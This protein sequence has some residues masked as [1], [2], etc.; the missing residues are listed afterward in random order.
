MVFLPIIYDF[1]LIVS[2]TSHL[3]IEFIPG[4]KSLGKFNKSIQKKETKMFDDLIDLAI[5]IAAELAKE[6]IKDRL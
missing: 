5:D 3:Y 2:F 6:A 1:F 4:I